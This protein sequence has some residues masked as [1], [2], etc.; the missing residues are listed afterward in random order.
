[1]GNVAILITLFRLLIS[2]L[3]LPMS[4]QVGAVQVFFF[5]FGLL[6]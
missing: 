6:R 3:Y 2:L 1:M 5:C 4:L